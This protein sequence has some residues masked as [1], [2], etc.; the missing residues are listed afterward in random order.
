MS[1]ARLAEVREAFQTA[2]REAGTDPE[3]VEKVRIDFAGRR[4]GVLQELTAA[5]RELPKEQKREYGQALNELKKLVTGRLEDKTANQN[6]RIFAIYR[7]D[8]DIRNLACDR[9]AQSP[10]QALSRSGRA[11]ARYGHRQSRAG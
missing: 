3:R 8:N 6:P 4:S 10:G 5:L 11:S 9:L 7:T 1:T 2:L